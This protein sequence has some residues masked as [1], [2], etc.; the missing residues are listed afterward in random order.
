[1]IC[2]VCGEN[3]T[4]ETVYWYGLGFDPAGW[5]CGQCLED[6]DGHDK[7]ETVAEI[8]GLERMEA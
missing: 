7:A 4:N 8:L 5:T 6:L 1:M 2:V 3:I